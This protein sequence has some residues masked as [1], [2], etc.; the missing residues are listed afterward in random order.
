MINIIINERNQKEYQLSSD[1]KNLISNKLDFNKDYPITLE[2]GFV[3]LENPKLKG[4]D[5]IL[6]SRPTNKFV[7]ESYKIL[8]NISTILNT[9]DNGVFVD[10]K[11]TNSDIKINICHMSNEDDLLEYQKNKYWICD[12]IVKFIENILGESNDVVK[13]NNCINLKN[14][15]YNILKYE[16]INRPI[17]GFDDCIMIIDITLNK[18][19]WW[20][21][22]EWIDSNGNVV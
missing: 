21:G 9:K 11:Y 6:A 8:K 22:S 4:C 5:I 7:S 10:N 12:E 14:S 2:I 20:I 13:L 16:S 18:P 3:D 1:M 17:L 19:I 15:Y